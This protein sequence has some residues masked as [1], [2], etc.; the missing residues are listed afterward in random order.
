MR[1]IGREME[2]GI[3]K[4]IGVSSP[5][6]CLDDGCLMHIFSFLSPIPG[7]LPPLP[8]SLPNPS[9]SRDFDLALQLILEIEHSF[10]FLRKIYAF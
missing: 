2:V 5:I 3:K 1:E 8:L 10:R 9:N 4:R 6:Q 7:S